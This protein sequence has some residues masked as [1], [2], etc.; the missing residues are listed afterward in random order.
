MSKKRLRAAYHHWLIL[1]VL[2]AVIALFSNSAVNA[3]STEQDDDPL[4]AGATLR[5]GSRRYRHEGET[6]SL[7]FSPNKKVLAAGASDGKVY[8]WQTNT[9]KLIRRLDPGRSIGCYP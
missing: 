8:L 6:F 3:A 7:A 1:T 9:G 2:T 5:L 4:P